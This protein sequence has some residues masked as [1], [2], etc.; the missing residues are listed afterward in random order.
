M[1]LTIRIQ[2]FPANKAWSQFSLREDAKILRIAVEN[3]KYCSASLRLEFYKIRHESSFVMTLQVETQRSLISSLGRIDRKCFKFGTNENPY[4][5]LQKVGWGWNKI[6][7]E[8]VLR[9]FV[10]ENLRKTLL[11][12]DFRLLFPDTKIYAFQYGTHL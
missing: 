9:Q 5:W 12:F 2:V 6:S 10:K 11:P 3:N 1:L 8:K 4:Y 7:L